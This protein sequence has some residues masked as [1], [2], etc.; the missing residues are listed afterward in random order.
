MFISGS[1]H[2]QR[3][4][5]LKKSVSIE[6]LI[7]N[8]ESGLIAR[9]VPNDLAVADSG[10]PILILVAS[11]DVQADRRDAIISDKRYVGTDGKVY[12]IQ[13]TIID[14]GHNTEYVY[15]YV[16]KHSLGV[17]ACKGKDYL[18]NGETYQFFSAS[19]LEKI[20]FRNALHISTG[21]LRDKI[22]NAMTSLF[23]I[24]GQPQPWW[25]PNFREDF[26][27]DYFKQFEAES[28]GEKSDAITKQFRGYIW[29]QKFGQDNHALTAMCAI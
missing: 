16:K 3:R 1:A 14:S 8:D 24:T 10:S 19:A 13:I 27:D 23:W 11:V 29:K 7:T 5:Q 12:R 28:R 6:T 20:G 25:Y 2:V 26:R 21:K 17:F 9:G 4:A 18:T 15:Q 22:S